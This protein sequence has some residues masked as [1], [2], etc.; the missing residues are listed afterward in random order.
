MTFEFNFVLVGLMQIVGFFVQGCTG[1]GCTVIAAAV[2]N[3]LL[4][5]TEGV[6]YGT[7]ITLPFLYF[8]GIKAFKEVSWK[9]LAKII[10]LCM[11]GI[12]VGNYLFHAISPVVAKICIGGMVTFIALMNIYK[13]I[14]KP[15]V[16]KKNEE[17]EADTT[18]KKV[19]DSRWR[20]TRCVQHWRTTD[21]SIYDLC[22][23][24]KR[25]IQK[26]YEYGMG[27]FEYM[28]CILTVQKR[29]SYTAFVECTC[30]W[31]TDGSSW[32]LCGY[33]IPE[34]N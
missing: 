1:F 25:K 9:D 32:F 23:K 27:Y 22:C 4:G 31:C 18:F 19:S 30:G 20:C 24:R 6:P 11:P 3:G 7:L 12:L 29:R 10:V 17:E 15:L 34:E 5:T 33:G 2:T 13:H 8:L 26:Y 21:Y 16:L 14:I 28:E